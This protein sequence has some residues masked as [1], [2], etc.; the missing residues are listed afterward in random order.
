MFYFQ[1]ERM[2]LYS[3]G[4]YGEQ[5][6]VSG[7]LWESEELKYNLTR[8]CTAMQSGGRRGTTVILKTTWQQ[9]RR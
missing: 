9:M 3:I 4:T 7:Y 6:N 2:Q 8:G 1:C 5:T